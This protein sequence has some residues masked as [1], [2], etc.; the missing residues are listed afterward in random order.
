MPWQCANSFCW[1]KLREET[2]LSFDIWKLKTAMLWD[3]LPSDSLS[4]RIFASW[5]HISD[6]TLLQH[7]IDY[8][9]EI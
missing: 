1:V 8:F 3:V 7:Q 4:M 6:A 2:A 5:F 9:P